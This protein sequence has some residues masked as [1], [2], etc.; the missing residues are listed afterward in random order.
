[1]WSHFPF[2]AFI[3]AARL[4]PPVFGFH[5]VAQAS[6]YI[7]NNKGPEKNSRPYSIVICGSYGPFNGGYILR[8][9][10]HSKALSHLRPK[11]DPHFCSTN[12]PRA[13]RINPLYPIRPS[14]TFTAI[15]T[16][17]SIDIADVSSTTASSAATNG[18]ASRSRSR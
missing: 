4:A 3:L 5:L 1:M 7:N 15:A 2:L 12:I 11:L 18:A 9:P 6:E 17:S 16:A 14:I 10:P 13:E 8:I